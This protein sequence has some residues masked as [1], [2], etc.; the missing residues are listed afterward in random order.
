MVK[1]SSKVH[2]MTVLSPFLLECEFLHSLAQEP[3]LASIKYWLLYPYLNKA[4]E[5][6]K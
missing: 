3:A 4:S 2:V 5:R 1:A 6:Q